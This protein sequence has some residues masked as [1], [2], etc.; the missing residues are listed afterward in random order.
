M[1]SEK[2]S[3]LG[4][5]SF[6]AID[7]ET[8]GLNIYNNKII[9]ISACKYI[10]CQLTDTFSKL[11]NPDMELSPF[12]SNL[13]GI[14]NKDLSNKPRF[15]DIS[16]EF[17]E[18]I[19]DLPIV[20]HN[21]QFDLDFINKE[22]DAKFNVYNQDYIC[23]TY[24]LSRIFLFYSNS[25]KLSS[26]CEILDINVNISHRAEDDAINSAKLF[27]KLLDVIGQV[28][29]N[30]L[31]V[32]N[33]CI[34][35]S[36]TI[37]R[38][39]LNNII[40]NHIDS[41]TNNINKN[42]YSE[43]I[44]ESFFF[45]NKSSNK[46]TS[47]NIEDIFYNDGLLSKSIQ[48]YEFRENQFNFS[49]DCL[50]NI[51]NSGILIAEAETGIGKSFSYL[52]SSLLTSKKVIVSSSTHNLQNQLFT[53]DI[54]AISKSIDADLSSTIVKGMSNY[55]CKTR[56]ENIINQINEYLDKKEIQ[57]FLPIVIWSE[58]TKTG[59]ISECNGF[60]VK[61]N[62]KIWN[63]VK[64]EAEI[65][66]T[67]NESYHK[68]CFYQN[69]I[70]NAKKSNLLVVNHALLVSSL[71]NKNG[72]I[73]ENAVCIIDEAHKLIE[74]CREQLKET[75]RVSNIQSLYDS[76]VLFYNKI[77]TKVET[78]IFD[79]QYNSIKNK[80]ENLISD[81][82]V[83]SLEFGT[84]LLDDQRILDY[85]N[86]LDIRYKINSEIFNSLSFDPQCFLQVTD[87]IIKEIESVKKD[88]NVNINSSEKMIFTM[89]INR[90][91][92]FYEKL[93]IIFNSKD[94]ITWATI[95]LSN[96]EM[97]YVTFHSAPFSIKSFINDLSMKFDSLV[98]C[99]ATLTI[100][101]EFDYFINELGLDQYVHEKMIKMKSY[102]SN[103]YRE[104]QTKLFIL[105]TNLDINSYE[106]YLDIFK[107]ISK[108]KSDINKRTL[109]LCTSYKQIKILKEICLKQND[110]LDE[111]ILFQDPNSS[112]QILLNRY[113]N[114]K[115][116]ILIGTNTFWEGIDLPSDMLELLLII[117]LPFSN[118]FNPIVAAKIDYYR[119]IG[120]NP[121]LDYQLP[122]TILKLRQGIG[123]LIRNQNDMGVC[124]LLDPR[125]LNKKYGALIL[126][127]INL[128]ANKF[129]NENT[130]IYE[131]KKFLGC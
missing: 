115:G 55:L 27:F 102:S 56:Y 69:M 45:T 48:D 75:I 93:K 4:L 62:E 2:I 17:V 121:F 71:N 130:L 91:K 38:K 50:K 65:C 90:C 111:N 36:N 73:D 34:K 42:Y 80:F 6:V 105:N 30:S 78:I 70:K 66:S 5:R 54:P 101:G 112:R 31:S 131:S 104:D 67:E 32:L 81:F 122:E 61:D 52:I 51:E 47:T 124:A 126:D 117:K 19:K 53:K 15:N 82:K 13:T 110:Q 128:T 63:L 28:D 95:Y 84:Q 57:E 88:L 72:L 9:E 119:S 58:F 107:I 18:F 68:G 40:C 120:M 77:E 8:T 12:I 26:L 25:F 11:I 44:P 123:R 29:I 116:S 39:L 59:D 79:D 20:G 98:L 24:F 3:D 35:Y 108:I 14:N 1:L 96:K 49:N 22:L 43:R 99:S 87:K 100:N 33:R 41:N 94:R 37:N 106:Y 60:R 16:G 103:F 64:Y 118:P 10:N 85:N 114:N 23:D 97:K 21:I 86:R 76:F 109:V 113:I 92:D 129:S 89:I 127:S 74:N 46:N 125:I 83:F 7:V